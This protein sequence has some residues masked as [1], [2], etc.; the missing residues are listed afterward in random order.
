MD[1][2]HYIL[3]LGAWDSFVVLGTACY[4]NKCQSVD[5]MVTV[6]S[7]AW[8]CRRIFHASGSRSSCSSS[9]SCCCCGRGGVG[10]GVPVLRQIVDAFNNSK[11]L[12]SPEDISTRSTY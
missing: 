11:S 9:S 8:R 4:S 1:T 6:C 5:M 2:G 7:L 3:S 12:T 10:G